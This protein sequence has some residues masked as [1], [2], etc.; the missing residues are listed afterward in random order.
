MENQENTNKSIM[1]QNEVFEEKNYYSSI[2]PADAEGQK[3]LF[4]ALDSCDLKIS[5]QIG[6]TIDLKDVYIEK[7]IKDEN[8]EKK[9]KIRTILFDKDGKSYVSTA[10]GIFKSVVR[11]F[12][13]YGQ[14]QDWAAPLKVTFSEQQLKDGKRSFTLRLA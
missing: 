13:I 9:E 14:P 11:I 1:V 6:E 7:Y 8:G 12:R 2:T 5:D 4:N 10:F 3:K